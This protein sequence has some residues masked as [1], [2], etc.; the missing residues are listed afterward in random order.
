MATPET[1]MLARKD[2][3]SVGRKLQGF[4]EQLS[5]TEQGVMAW[6][7]ARAAFGIPPGGGLLPPH[8]H[9]RPRG[10]KHLVLGGADGLL[11]LF[12]YHGFRVIHPEGPLPTDLAN[13][14][15]A[16]ILGAD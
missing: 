7:M 12:G 15:G 16:A 4:V 14:V 5:P 8:P 3:E 6:L 10:G 2:F 13:N 9:Y 11:V 1:L